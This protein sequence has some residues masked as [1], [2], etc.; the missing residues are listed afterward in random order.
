MPFYNVNATIS[1]AAW[2]MVEA[3]S[4][5]AAMEEARDMSAGDFD[6]DTGTGEVDF[7]VTPEVETA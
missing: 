1:F 4:P 2:V 7:N 3:E 6:Y 5:D